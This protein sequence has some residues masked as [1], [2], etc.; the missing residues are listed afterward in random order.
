LPVYQ[1]KIVNSN[2]IGGGLPMSSVLLRNNLVT[3][4]LISG[5]SFAP[6]LSINMF[7]TLI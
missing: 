3:G 5:N 6:S 1:E 4:V 2:M 7:V